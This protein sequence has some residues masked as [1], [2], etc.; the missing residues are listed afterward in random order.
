MFLIFSSDLSSDDDFS[1]TKES[2]TK[3]SILINS[4]SDSREVSILSVNL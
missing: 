4:D 2:T 1:P 3:E